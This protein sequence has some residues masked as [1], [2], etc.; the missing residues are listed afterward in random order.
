M[1]LTIMKTKTRMHRSWPL[2][3]ISFALGG[4]A[5]HAQTPLR[6]GP[7]GAGFPAGGDGTWNLAGAFWTPDGGANYQAW[8]TVGGA[9]ATAIFGYTTGTVTVNGPITAGGLKF[10]YGFYTLSV[11]G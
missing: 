9:D 4:E 6:W 8:P 11:G 7:N 5:L 1:S 10:S 2:L 3:A